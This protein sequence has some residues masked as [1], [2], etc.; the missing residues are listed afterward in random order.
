MLIDPL[1]TFQGYCENQRELIN[2]SF[3]NV[4]GEALWHERVLVGLK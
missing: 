4:Q 3:V 2:T 1:P